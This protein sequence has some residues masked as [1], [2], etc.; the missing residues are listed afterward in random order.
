V[1]PASPD[2]RFTPYDVDARAAIDEVLEPLREETARVD[3]EVRDTAAFLDER[4]RS[5][6][7]AETRD[8]FDRAAQ[9]PEAP[10]AMR[11]L[12]RRVASGE[13]GW[14]DV[15]ARRGG[16]DGEAFLTEA[17]RTA[18]QQFADTD[19]ARVP[20]PEAALEAGVDP[21]DVADDIDRTRRGARDEHD[22]IFRRAFEDQP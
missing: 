3:R 14:D 22:A 8:L 12:A 15:F 1:P 13:L 19:L 7:D 2:P 10:A 4:R 21:A 18:R 11:R 6:L 16:P 5:R 9:S 20:V 17:F